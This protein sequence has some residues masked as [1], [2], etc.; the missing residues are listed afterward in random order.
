VSKRKLKDRD[1][2]N[3]LR[4]YSLGGGGGDREKEVLIVKEGAGER[5]LR[6][7]E[8]SIEY[9]V[10]AGRKRPPEARQLK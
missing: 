3:K 2:R 7:I 1:I 10:R 6:R 9:A 8:K 5:Y 4:E